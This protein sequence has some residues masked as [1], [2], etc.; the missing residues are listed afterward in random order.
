MDTSP[1]TVREYIARAKFHTQKQDLLKSMKALAH[2]LDLLAASQIFGRER[3]EIGILLDEAVRLLMEQ[4]MMKRF[5]P[6]GLGYTKGK[7]RELSHTL[8]RLAAALEEALAKRRIEERR[9]G[10]MELDE[11]MLSAQA[12]LDKKEPLEARRLFRKAMEQYGEEHGLLVD[13][14]TR[15]MLAGLPAEACEYFQKSIEVAPGDVRAFMLLSQCLEGLGEVEKAEE[16]LKTIL[17]RFGPDEA[18]LMRLGKAA[19]ARRKWDEALVCVQATLKV[20]P[21]NQEAHKVGA[22]VGTRLFGD[23]KAYLLDNPKRA[24]KASTTSKTIT[25]DF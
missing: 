10:L 3:I 23:A 12:E 20:N 6:N 25:V 1:K 2:A 16:L 18:I 5:L 14:G 19:L 7:E 13:I 21:Q 17:R 22:E 24:A 11:L 8:K 9:K 15:L 4:D